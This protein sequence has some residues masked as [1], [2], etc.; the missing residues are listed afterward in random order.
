MR[1]EH[2]AMYVT[3]LETEEEFFETYFGAKA[4]EKYVH[5]EI[6]FSSYFL[7]FQDGARLEL[8]HNIEMDDG[9][10]SGK[11]TGFIHIAFAVGERGNVNDITERIKSAGYA[12]IS[13]PR[14]TG[15]G[16]YESCVLDPE[17]NQ[18]EIT[19]G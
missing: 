18:V 15:D 12:V 2:I 10:K 8:M 5:E 6:G 7:T 4:G 16:Y 13:G 1:I 14:T 17:G 3:D 19:T 9:K 11:R